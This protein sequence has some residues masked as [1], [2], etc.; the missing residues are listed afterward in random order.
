MAGALYDLSTLLPVQQIQKSLPTFWLNYFPSEITFD[1]DEI[2]WDRVYKDNR[3]L[4]PF[5]VPTSKGVPM[6][7]SG[8]DSVSF[9]P[10]YIKQKDTVDP[11]KPFKRMAGESLGT[12]SL[13]PQQRYDA[14]VAQ[15][16][17][18][19]KTYIQ[20]RWEWMAAK[21]LIDGQV[22]I[23]GE[24]YPSRLV[25]FRRSSE[26]SVV[27][28]GAAKWDQVTGN[29][30]ADLKAA[31]VAANYRSGARITK[32]IFG[33]TAWDLFTTRVDLRS[34]M[35]TQIDGYGTRVTMLADGYEGM[36]Y[37]G[38]VQGLDGSGRVECW[39]NT[40]K[41]VDENNT[42]QFM[43]DQ[44]TVVGLADPQSIAGVRCFG[45]IKDKGANFQ[46]LSIYP[47]MWAEEDPAADF[48]MSQSAPLMVPI[49]PNATYSIKV[50]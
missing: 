49:N 28:A 50:A 30:L 7:D 13:T 22:T 18:N 45:A 42:E 9:K 2:I 40:Q 1:T 37:M 38:V 10:A 27:L 44:S 21:A 12:G 15:I 36:E 29:P 23:S 33:Q 5:V 35:Q 34:Q 19:Q 48:M 3:R 46:A 4:A 25:N 11:T 24:N 8:Y 31:R 41:Y 43:M 16:L 47:K 32:H 20:N 39:V 6:G 17:A 14:L 26:L